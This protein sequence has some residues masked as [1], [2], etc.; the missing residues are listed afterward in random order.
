M[1]SATSCEGSRAWA[2]EVP[3]KVIICLEDICLGVSHSPLSHLGCPFPFPLSSPQRECISIHIGQAG[4]QIGNAC[5]ELYCL[6]HGI[7]P[8]GQMSSEKPIGVLDQ[9]LDTFFSDTGTGK[10]V[11]RAVFADLE[12][13]VIG[14][15]ALGTRSRARSSVLGEPLVPWGG[16]WS[17]TGDPTASPLQ[18]KFAL[19]PTASC[20]TLTSSSLAGKMPPAT[21][22]VATTLLA[23]RSLSLCKSAS[24]SW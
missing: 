9:S 16:T 6:E 14:E 18:M 4:V 19:A 21:M 15:L 24:A 20:S 12:P 10:H 23:G 5:W 11:P 2:G 22:P 7:Q 3:G 8:D 1:S 13:T 17:V